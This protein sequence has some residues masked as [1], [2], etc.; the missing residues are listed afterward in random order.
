MYLGFALELELID[1]GDHI[2]VSQ[3]PQ[4]HTFRPPLFLLHTLK[5]ARAHTHNHN[6]T[7]CMINLI[8]LGADTPDNTKPLPHR[9]S[10][11]TIWHIMRRQHEEVALTCD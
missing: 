10:P 7:P 6:H 11:Q 3:H 2:R 9:Q 8:F 1:E 5:R 4:E